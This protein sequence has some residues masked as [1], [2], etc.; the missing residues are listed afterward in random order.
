MNM[1]KDNPILK[2]ETMMDHYQNP[3]NQELIKDDRYKQIH[4]YLDSCLD[5]I[6]L[7]VL[8]VEDVIEDIRFESKAC[9]IATAAT[10]IMSELLKNKSI[11]EADVIIDNYL[12]MIDQNL[13][14]ASLLNEALVFDNIGKQ[15]NRIGCATMSWKGLKKLLKESKDDN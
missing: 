13:Y 7:Q 9:V 4:L 1:F 15:V 2:R 14:D 3:R 10:S 12:K 8:V 5:D 11:E 6:N